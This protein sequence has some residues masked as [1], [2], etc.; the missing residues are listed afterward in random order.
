MGGEHKKT[1]D[2]QMDLTMPGKSWDILSAAATG[3]CVGLDE[4]F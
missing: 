4:W 3:L 2:S 1:K